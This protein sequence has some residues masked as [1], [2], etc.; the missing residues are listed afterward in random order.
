MTNSNMTAPPASAS[1][2]SP[3]ANIRVG[4]YGPVQTTVEKFENGV[5]APHYAGDN[6]RLFWIFVR[7]DSGKEYS[8]DCRVVSGFENL[9]FHNVFGPSES[10]KSA[11]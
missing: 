7:G 6:H 4:L 11:F 3:R 10:P 2:P 8:R 9:R 1:S 5:F